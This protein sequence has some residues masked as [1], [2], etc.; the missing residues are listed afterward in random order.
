MIGLP[1]EMPPS[2]SGKGAWLLISA[3]VVVLLLA[4]AVPAVIFWKAGVFH[5]RSSG[6]TLAQRPRAP[7][8]SLHQQHVPADLSQLQGEG[9]VYLV[10]IGPQAIR[11]ESLLEH[12]QSKFHLKLQVLP[13]LPLE[14]RAF[15]AKR[16]QYILEEMIG[17]MKRAHPELVPDTRAVMIALTNEDI[18]ARSNGEEYVCTYR[19]ESRYAVVSTRR[20][21][22]TFWGSPAKPDL[23]LRRLEHTLTKDIA[24]LHY[25]LSLSADPESVLDSETLPDPRPDDIWESDVHPEESAYG[26]TGEHYC[27][28]LL[29]SYRTGQTVL[30]PRGRDC[31]L[32]D[33]R[34]AN[35][36]TF[37]IFPAGGRFS[38]YKTDFNLGGKPEI[39]FTRITHPSGKISH[40]FGKGGDH[41][42]DT[43][44]VAWNPARMDAMD[45][46]FP[47]A[48]RWHFARTSPGH[49]FSPD[50]VFTSKDEGDF[51]GAR[52]TW[53]GSN[54]VVK[55][56][57][58]ESY[59]YL[60]C[61]GNTRC[62]ENFYQDEDGNKL[63]YTRSPD[64]SLTELRSEQ[65]S[66]TFRYDGNARIS[67]AEDQSGH[68]VRY[69]Y[70]DAGY[71]AKVTAASGAVTT[72]ERSS[73]GRS[74]LISVTRKGRP[75]T[76]IFSAEFDGEGRIVKATVPRQGDYTFAYDLDGQHVTSVVITS[77]QGK[78][79]SVD[80]D[81]EDGSFE[82]HSEE[83]ILPQDVP[84]A[85]SKKP[86]DP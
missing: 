27:L 34:D 18:Y 13:P 70:D 1:G 36:E 74:L 10:P 28:I 15:D 52:I 25:N 48:G 44:L 78:K 58:G 84:S 35:L 81:E 75:K 64:Q 80:Y 8:P 12:Y 67:A 41:F 86:N 24:V 72:Y 60:P 6:Y 59:L 77:P 76:T 83:V 7:R 66:L 61:S 69:E 29:Y 37:H 71:L 26:L 11:P 56:A 2:R 68:T 20:M 32:P 57:S 42:Y 47:S 55:Q 82:A 73:D 85:A 49:G 21:D 79:L 51:Y 19:I 31:T 14:P 50:M 3:V 17:Q 54:Y 33:W 23:T 45:L 22:D 4:V 39:V 5:P 30:S 43:D 62:L 65:K 53:D 40:A 46:R 63:I 9:A 38:I 16:K